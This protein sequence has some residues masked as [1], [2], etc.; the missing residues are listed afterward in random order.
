[1]DL[2]LFVEECINE[3]L[4]NRQIRRWCKGNKALVYRTK[5]MP[6]DKWYVTKASNSLTNRQRIERKFA[7]VGVEFAN[8]RFWP[9]PKLPRD[10]DA[11]LAHIDAAMGA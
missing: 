2:D 8:D 11:E 4:T 3:L 1:M 6:E 5:D 10:L 9:A 7:S